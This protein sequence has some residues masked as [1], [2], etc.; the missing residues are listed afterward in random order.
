LAGRCVKDRG[1][2]ISYWILLVRLLNHTRL[3]NL[4]NEKEHVNET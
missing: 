2:L 4:N 3:K 1:F